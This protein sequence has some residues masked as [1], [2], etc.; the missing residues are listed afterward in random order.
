[1]PYNLFHNMEKE[2]K[3][4]GSKNGTNMQKTQLK[5]KEIKNTNQNSICFEG[6]FILEDL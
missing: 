3:E 5:A 1:M 2:V 4:R 6:C